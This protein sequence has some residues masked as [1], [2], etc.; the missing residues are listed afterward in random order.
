[1]TDPNAYWNA[2]A[3]RGTAIVADAP[4]VRLYWARSCGLVGK[5][6]AVVRVDLSGVNYGGGVAYLDNRTGQGWWKVTEGR[7][8]SEYG[9]GNVAVEDG[10][11]V[12]GPQ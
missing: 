9:H 5:R 2:T 3:E 12:A 8:S 11:W 10:S 1:M 7:G 6:I 4:E